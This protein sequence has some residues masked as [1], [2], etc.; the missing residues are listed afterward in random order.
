MASHDI[1][2][3]LLEG[4][5]HPGPG[6]GMGTGMGMEKRLLPVGFQMEGTGDRHGYINMFTW[7]P[8]AERKVRLSSGGA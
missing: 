7:P 3:S 6:T 1:S 8:E 5:V 4:G 2:P